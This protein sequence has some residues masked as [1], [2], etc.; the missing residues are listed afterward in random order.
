MIIQLGRQLVLQRVLKMMARRSPDFLVGDPQDPQLRRWWIIPKNPFFALYAHELCKDDG[1][2][3]HDHPYANISW[4]LQIGYFEYQFNRDARKSAR[5]IPPNYRHEMERKYRPE[6]SLIARWAKRA[7]RI[8]L[9]RFTAQTMASGDKSF[10]LTNDQGAK[11]ALTE[12]RIPHPISLF[13]CGPR[14][15]G[16]GFYCPQGFRPYQQY[17]AKHSY[18][19]RIGKGCEE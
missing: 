18:G 10:V 14:F 8:E 15:H 19:N 2:V 16:W 12:E 6:G 1:D 13:F 5:Q 9:R 7:H 4:I 11:S 3:P 17:I